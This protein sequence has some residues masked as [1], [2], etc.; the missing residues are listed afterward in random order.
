MGLGGRWRRDSADVTRSGAITGQ[1]AAVS[2]RSVLILSEA[3]LPHVRAVRATDTATLGRLAQSVGIASAW[4]D[5]D[6]VSHEVAPDTLQSLLAAMRWPAASSQQAM[7]SL[8]ALADLHDRRPLP[9]VLVRR[10]G[11]P[12]E[13][14]LRFDPGDPPP[15]TWLNVEGEDGRAQRLRASSQHGVTRVVESRD[16]RPGTCLQL[17]LPPLPVG[18]YRLTREDLPQATCGL[19]IAPTASFAP[20]A[21]KAGSRVFGLSSQ[22][23]A[24]RRVGDQGIGDFGTLGE[25]AEAAAREGAGALAINPL[26]ALFSAQRER[27]SPYF[28]SDRR[29]LDPIYLDLDQLGGGGETPTRRRLS[30]FPNVDYPGVW[31]LKS[32]A[33]EAGFANADLAGLDD[34]ITT[35]GEAL[36]AFA[37]FEAIAETMPG[38]PWCEWPPEMRDPNGASVKAFAEA[39]RE[40]IRFHQYLQMLCERQLA[41][42]AG[43]AAGLQIGLCRDLAVGAA[44]DG[45]EAWACARLL[46]DAA[47]IGAPPDQFTADGQV[48]GL[49]PFDPLRMTADGYAHFAQVLS[50][51][52]RHAGALRIDHV[53]G[54]A[55]Q[56]WVPVGASAAEGAY[57]GY[58]LGDLLGE[59]ALESYRAGCLVIGEDLG[60]AADGLRE[61][62]T[63]EA[64]LSYRVLPFEAEAGVLRRPS[65]FPALA[66]ACVATHDLPPFAGWWR[67]TDI[68]ERSR[69]KL[70]SDAAVGR[71]RLQ[72]EANK[73]ALMR[74]LMSAGLV[75]PD[76]DCASIPVSEIIIAAH[77]F[78]ARTPCF[79][80]MAQIEDLAGETVAVNLPGTDQ[81]RPNW[82]RRVGAELP[83]IMR[84]PGAQAILSAMRQ[85]ARTP[86]WAPGD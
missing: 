74:A 77:A 58:P 51:N 26:H 47:S 18:R 52:M 54:L 33:L 12:I 78:I 13:V 7:N 6:G 37:I 56:F 32:D 35:R 20:D 67:G 61:A 75:E 68:D 22:L 42:A 15:R 72:R 69:L 14:P 60:T 2:A 64:I 38:K 10:L 3:T 65:D 85:A 79:L 34:F 30:A 17:T 5:L 31:R 76:L 11:E 48:W 23:Y 73:A 70:I 9:H 28:P 84:S 41:R 46:A 8:Q 86:G 39:H 81:E 1:S 27:A 55:R 66:L 49:P 57:V 62:L 36:A 45:A 16:G 44:P 24:A 82:R 83:E 59:L 53:L 21:L 50:S 29:F 63:R 25:L 19:T 43:Q 71:A 80:A 4:R 40:R